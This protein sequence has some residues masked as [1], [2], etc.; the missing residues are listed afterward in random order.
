[1]RIGKV[2]ELSGAWQQWADRVG[3]KTWSEIQMIQKDINQQ[4]IPIN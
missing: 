1:M 4:N 2:E 3:V